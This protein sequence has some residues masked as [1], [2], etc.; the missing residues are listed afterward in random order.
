[1]SIPAHIDRWLRRRDAATL[2]AVAHRCDEL[3]FELED[4][5]DEPV[6]ADHDGRNV[7]ERRRAGAVTLQLE[8]VRCGKDSCRS[9]PHGPY[10][11]AYFRQGRRIRSVYIG[12][13][14]N[15]AHMILADT[16]GADPSRWHQVELAPPQPEE[17][18]EVEE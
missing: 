2:R 6:E 13:D 18:S 8:H 12:K 17:T 3:L 15:R 10:W 14:I 16:P 11:Y 1:M 4:L 9:C 5:E 7:V